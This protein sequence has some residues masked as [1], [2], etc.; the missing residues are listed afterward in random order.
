VRPLESS[1]HGFFRYKS[2]EGGIE[3][4]AVRDMALVSKSRS[5]REKKASKEQ[6]LLILKGVNDHR[7]H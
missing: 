7:A 4:D 5:A 2:T 3:K 1:Y 6:S